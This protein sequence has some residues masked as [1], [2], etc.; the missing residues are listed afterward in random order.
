MKLLTVQI[1]KL[2]KADS[3]VCQRKERSPSTSPKHSKSAKITE[4]F[5]TDPGS[6]RETADR[7][8]SSEV[9]TDRLRTD[10]QSN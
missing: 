6:R 8:R 3:P 10:S 1:P 7:K 5:I 2:F 9:R 4:R